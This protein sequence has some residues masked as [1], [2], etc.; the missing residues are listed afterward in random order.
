MLKSQLICYLSLYI[1]ITTVAELRVNLMC[2]PEN[3]SGHDLITQ[4][5]QKY[6]QNKCS[7]PVNLLHICPDPEGADSR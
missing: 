6:V 4:K 5:I 1:K 2:L 7:L 3:Y